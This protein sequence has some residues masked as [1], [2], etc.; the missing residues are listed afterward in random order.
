[1]RF[2]AGWRQLVMSWFFSRVIYPRY[3]SSFSTVSGA[4]LMAN[5]IDDSIA[6]PGL[7]HR[8]MDAD[9]DLITDLM[10]GT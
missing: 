8:A 4:S 6:A 2:L 10:G 9:L 1:M 3:L 7:A 5:V